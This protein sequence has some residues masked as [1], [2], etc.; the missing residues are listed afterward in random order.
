MTDQKSMPLFIWLNR[1]FWLIWLCFPGL[2][3]I[4]ARGVLKA[5]ERLSEMAP[6][7]AAC[8]A[9]LPQL[10]LFS[11]TGTVIFWVF[12]ALQFGVYA[13]FLGLAHWV[14]HR[15]AQGRIFVDSMIGV[16]RLT[17]ILIALWPILDLMLNN[18]ITLALVWTGDFPV[19]YADYALDL[20]VLGVGLL[21][22]TISVA[23]RQAV[24]LREDAELTI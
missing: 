9:A 6:E 20:P 21:V 24:R 22:F 11:P 12:F 2:I 17:G 23:M 8:L 5:P 16:L 3:W 10:A 1:A 15:C 19:F 14:I 18:L 7:Q 4:V 13:M